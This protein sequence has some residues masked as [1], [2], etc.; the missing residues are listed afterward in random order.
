MEE[1][2]A[3]GVRHGASS[4]GERRRRGAAKQPTVT[5]EIGKEAGTRDKKTCELDT[6]TPKPTLMLP[7][8]TTSSITRTSDV[9]E[10]CGVANC[11]GSTMGNAPPS[12]SQDSDMI[13]GTDLSVL[14]GERTEVGDG[15][16]ELG[17]GKGPGQGPEN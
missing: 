13:Y 4:S 7:P 5:I 17:E 11:G 2:G 9:G 1:G 15:A 12:M 8:H 16:E 3:G 10:S 14:S 6:S